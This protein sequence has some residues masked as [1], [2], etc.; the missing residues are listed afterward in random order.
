LAACLRNR[1]L[2]D[3]FRA[4]RAARRNKVAWV[5]LMS[6]ALTPAF[7]SRSALI[8]WARDRLM[9]PMSHIAP[10][11]RLM[12]ATLTGAGAMPAPRFRPRP[13]KSLP[14]PPRANLP[15]PLAP[16]GEPAPPRARSETA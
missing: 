14:A 1:T 6:R 11:E 7:Q 12:L 9:F 10:L 15:P 2:D 13:A 5:Q 3:A 16:S 8:G 4:Y